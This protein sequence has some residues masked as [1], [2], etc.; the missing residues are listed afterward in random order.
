MALAHPSLIIETIVAEGD[1]AT[2]ISERSTDA[3]LVVLGRH[4]QGRLAKMLLG[5]TSESA[6][7]KLNV[8][9]V[10]VPCDEDEPAG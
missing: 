1:A 6:L 5:S 4:R 10:I 3:V 9:L 7:H 2:V 8:P